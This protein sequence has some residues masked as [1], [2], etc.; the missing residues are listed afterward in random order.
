MTLNGKEHKKVSMLYACNVEA[1]IMTEKN[2][3]TNINLNSTLQNNF[4]FAFLRL[5]ELAFL[6]RLHHV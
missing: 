1:K 6:R 4:L 2:E 5:Q 3:N